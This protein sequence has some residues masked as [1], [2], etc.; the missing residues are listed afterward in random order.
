VFTYKGEN[1]PLA[2]PAQPD[3][4]EPGK[5]IG[6]R[7]RIRPTITRT[8]VRRLFDHLG[9]TLANKEQKL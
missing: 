4:P 1:R 5:S 7:L 8:E 2:S 3:Y 6:G 9:L